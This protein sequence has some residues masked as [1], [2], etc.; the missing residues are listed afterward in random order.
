MRYLVFMSVVVAVAFWAMGC[1]GDRDPG[2]S[3]RDSYE[4][5][6]ASGK[7]VLLD[8]GADGCPTCVQMKPFVYKAISDYRGELEVV[9]IDTNV[10]RD[11]ASQYRVRAIPTY[12][13]IKPGGETV[14]RAMG[15]IEASDFD[16]KI[17]QFIDDH[18]PAE[19]N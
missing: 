15:F 11:L 9:M 6:M 14:S 4:A 13:F 1:S 12:V 7:P 18:P 16:S 17:R 3:A 8:F 5:A 10:D 19:I 2:P